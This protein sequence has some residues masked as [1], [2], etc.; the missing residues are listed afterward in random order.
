MP[1][2]IFENERVTTTTVSHPNW[3]AIWGGTFTFYAIWAIFG[4]LGTAIFASAANPNAAHPITG[5]SVGMSVWAVILTIIAM[6]V[7]GRVTG[8]L[9]GIA[10]RRDGVVHGMT[11]FGLSVIGV[12]VLAVLEQGVIPG[13]I[14]AAGPHSAG[15]LTLF[16]DLG[17]AGFVALI[18]GWLAAMGGA[19][20]GTRNIAV[21]ETAVQQPQQAKRA[22]A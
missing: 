2:R 16:A 8:D 22:A 1:E 3:G 10:N 21:G 4:V 13:S 15:L 12:V 5:M 14:A 11:M 7:G 6:Y 20:Q 18:L 9:A 17:W 19:A